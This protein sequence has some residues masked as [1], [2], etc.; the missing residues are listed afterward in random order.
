MSQNQNIQPAATPGGIPVNLLA[1]AHDFL[2][3]IVHDLFSNYF[4]YCDFREQ[5]VQ[6]ETWQLQTL[7]LHNLSKYWWS[8]WRRTMMMWC[9]LSKVLMYTT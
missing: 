6:L 2:L 1:R 8:K 3:Y 5:H 4:A 7:F 9:S